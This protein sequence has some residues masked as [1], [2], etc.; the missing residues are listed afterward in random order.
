MLETAHDCGYYLKKAEGSRF[1]TDVVEGTD[2]LEGRLDLALFY[3]GEEPG[4][5]AKY[6]DILEDMTGTGLHKKEMMRRYEA[7]YNGGLHIAGTMGSTMA[8]VFGAA[9]LI[10]PPF[11]LLE[12]LFLG[13]GAAG[14]HRS[15]KKVRYY[16][17]ARSVAPRITWS[18][19]TNA[20]R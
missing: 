3:Q 2:T 7:L 20:G 16:F 11:T 17:A 10:V 12:P 5:F 15:M 13:L 14:F 19:M 1:L 18:P 9:L 8:I 4:W 6:L